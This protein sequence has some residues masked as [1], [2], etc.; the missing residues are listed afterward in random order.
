LGKTRIEE[1]VRGELPSEKV[2]ALEEHL[3]GCFSCLE[4]ALQIARLA[5]S[6]GEL[7]PPPSDRVE[8]SSGDLLR[9]LA[10]YVSLPSPA[11]GLPKAGAIGPYRV[12]ETI[13]QGAMGVVYRAVHEQ[14]GKVV[15]IK[16]LALPDATALAAIR[17]ETAFL[18]RQRHPGIVSVIDDGML[19]G[20]PWFAMEWLQGL[21]LQHYCRMLRGESNAEAGERGGPHAG[22]VGA[23]ALR[24]VIELYVRL[25]SPL[26]F[27]HRSGIVHCDLAPNNVIV[28]ADGQPVLID[29]GLV[30]R[31]TGAIGRESLEVG[32]VFRGTLPYIAP[33]LIRGRIPDARADLYALG[34]N[35]FES[36][37]GR[38]PFVEGSVSAYARAHLERPP[39]VASSLAPAVPRALDDLLQALLAKKPSDRLG[40][41]E[42]VADLLSRLLAGPAGAPARA[43]WTP[44]LFRPRMLGR[45][46]IVDR[47]ALYRDAAARGQGALILL[48]GESGIGKTFL[49]SE[50]A[51]ASTNAGFCV[52]TGECSAVAPSPERQGFAPVTTL[53]PF[54]G[55][56]QAAFDRQLALASAPAG[57]PVPP[58]QILSRYLPGRAADDSAR[59]EALPSLPP[60]AERERV[61]HAMR[62]LLEFMMAASPLLLVLDDLQWADDLSLALLSDLA[63]RFVGDRPLLIL[64]FSRSEE[65][66]A[67]LTRLQALPGVQSIQIGRLGRSS[68]RTL[69]SELLSGPAADDLVRA[70]D[71]A[72]EGNPFFVAECLREAAAQGLLSYGAQGWALDAEVAGLDTAATPAPTLPL[73]RSLL[74]LVERR[75]LLLEAETQRA[76]EAAS[77]LGRGF[78]VTDLAIVCASPVHQCELWVDDMVRGQLV[79]RL[80][81]ESVRFTHD[82]LREAAYARIETRRRSLLHAR[83][84]HALESRYGSTPEYARR[85]GELA[86]HYEQ[87]KD[88]AKA[89][90]CLEAAGEHALD[91]SAGAEA[92]R[93]FRAALGCEAQSR[94]FVSVARRAYWQRRLGDALQS[95]GDLSGSK[96]ALLTAV[97][98]QGYPV[99]KAAGRLALSILGGVVT[100]AV[101]RAAPPRW[102][103]AKAGQA[104]ELI[105]TARAFDRLMQTYYYRGEYGPMLLANLSMLNL[106]E[107]GPVTSSLAVGYTNAAAVAGIIP[108]RKLAARYF[109]LAESVLERAYHPEVESHLRLLVAHYEHGLGHWEKATASVDRALALTEELGY[110]RRW[111]DGAGVRSNLAF[112]RDFDE[113]LSWGDKMYRSALRRGDA[114]GICWGLLRRAEI[115]AARG[116]LAEL[117]SELP[118]LEASAARQGRPEQLRALALRAFWLASVKRFREAMDPV[119]RAEEVIREAKGMHVYCIEAYAQLAHVRLAAWARGCDTRSGPAA[120]CRTLQAAAK[121]FPIATGRHCLSLGTWQWRMGDRKGALATWKRGLEVTESLGLP[122]DRSLLTLAMHAH[123]SRHVDRSSRQAALR[124]LTNLGVRDDGWMEKQL[125]PV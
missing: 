23:D 84:A 118:E 11:S 73:P 42:V 48:S 114:Q 19:D 37:T 32:G 28:R 64:G 91:R 70:V 81:D 21:T 57:S 22:P 3:D 46:P 65:A 8:S 99:P 12:E 34:C 53:Q 82:K 25:C 31:A 107:R 59:N 29:F 5:E 115:H 93:Y 105:E 13:G 74:T 7:G 58:F 47:L 83:A 62:E 36:L 30:S 90:D 120:A 104:A 117:E 77:V 110:L 52:V 87:C 97:A 2:P 56:I 54:A 45:R 60:E 75:L 20:S 15:A 96:A 40:D 100:Q 9:A 103:A 50:L 55:L 41:A 122:Y 17:Q 124:H 38:P 86:H 116:Q 1:F 108:L 10:R 43:T 49:A 121:L 39:P 24:A 101:H 102:Y 44:Y 88:F 106:V 33:E 71:T 67:D 66:A 4:I 89:I 79:T 80:R 119:H 26:S 63:Q 27:L 85:R 76:V 72:S 111:E 112:G 18:K 94:Q 14:T 109:E 98:L 51:R 6:S 123:S 78:S 61:L 113:S 68:I 125:S 69:T 95:I 35:L 16:T 92:A